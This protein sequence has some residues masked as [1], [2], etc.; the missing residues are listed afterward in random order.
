MPKARLVSKGCGHFLLPDEG[1]KDECCFFGTK[2]KIRCEDISVVFEN[3]EL[4]DV[5]E[6][7]REGCFIYVK[8]PENVC[9][10]CAKPCG[11]EMVADG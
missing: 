8:V 6:V 5:A 9:A 4:Q 10:E 1:N 7:R 11:D 3:I 2:P